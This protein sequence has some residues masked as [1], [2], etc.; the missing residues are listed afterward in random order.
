LSLNDSSLQ[1]L[2]ASNKLLESRLVSQDLLVAQLQGSHS[3]ALDQVSQLSLGMS[4]A[5]K[6]LQMNQLARQAL[7]QALSQERA[8]TGRLEKEV[9][10][11]QRTTRV[12]E[13]KVR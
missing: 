13:G 10:L 6:S 12:L 1:I 11:G 8:T 9:E 5:M 7:R 4:V 2:Q 3:R